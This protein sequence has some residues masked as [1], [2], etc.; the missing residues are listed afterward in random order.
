MIWFEMLA[1]TSVCLVKA[2]I[3]MDFQGTKSFKFVAGYPS[4]SSDTEMTLCEYDKLHC[5]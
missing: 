1:E 4:F 5:T 2:I 3:D